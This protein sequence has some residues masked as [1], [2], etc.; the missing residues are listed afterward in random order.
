MYRLCFSPTL[1]QSNYKQIMNT[2]NRSANLKRAD[3][4]W[5]STGVLFGIVFGS[6]TG[7]LL[8]GVSMGLLLGSIV[9]SVRARKT[10]QPSK[11]WLFVGGFALLWMIALDIIERA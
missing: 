8:A 2:P 9:I 10:E 6:F 7:D 3:A 11:I 5:I 1:L 4:K